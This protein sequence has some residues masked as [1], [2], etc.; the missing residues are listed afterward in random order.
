[1]NQL[2]NNIKD[3]P[4]HISI[5]HSNAYEGGIKLK[6]EIEQEFN[7]KE[8]WITDLSPIIAYATGTGVIIAAYYLDNA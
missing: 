6:K 3:S 4:V 2:K 8:L 1:M 7:C 5:A